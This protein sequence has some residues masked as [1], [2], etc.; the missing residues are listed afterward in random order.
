MASFIC[1]VITVCVDEQIFRQLDL[2]GEGQL[3]VVQ[4]RK[5]LTNYPSEGPFTDISSMVSAM[6][7]CTLSPGEYF[8]RCRHRHFPHLFGALCGQPM[9]QLACCRSYGD[10]TFAA[11]GCRLWNS[12]PVQLRD[13]DI[14][15]RLFRRQLKGGIPFPRCMST[16]PC[17]LQY[18]A[19]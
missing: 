8:H 10:R 4:L 3:N 6:K 16:V 17:D 14:T 9:F 2:E 1:F 5:T 13:T 15:Y 11:A 12:F 19:P 7:H 18:V